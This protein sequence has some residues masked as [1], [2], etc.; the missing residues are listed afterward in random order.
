MLLNST[1]VQLLRVVLGECHDWHIF[2]VPGLFLTLAGRGKTRCSQARKHIYV[3]I[4]SDLHHN[5]IPPVSDLI[6]FLWLYSPRS[7]LI[8]KEGKRK[9]YLTDTFQYRFGFANLVYYLLNR[10]PL[11]AGTQEASIAQN[12]CRS[13][14]SAIA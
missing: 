6:I 14:A 5:P 12:A 2:H 1:R 10:Q 4:F 11:G 7:I 9:A 3:G 8:G 13:D